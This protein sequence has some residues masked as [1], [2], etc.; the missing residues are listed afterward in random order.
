MANCVLW[1]TY[2]IL[3]GE[4]KIWGTNTVG[5]VFGAYYFVKFARFAPVKASTLPGSIRQHV[6]GILILAVSTATVAFLV[7]L[8][9]PSTFI[10]NGAILFCLLMFASPL[11]ALKTVL[12]S[13]SAKSIPLPF[14]LATILNCALWSVFGLLEIHDFNVYFPNLLGLSFGLV[15]LSLRLRYGD[16]SSTNPLTELDLLV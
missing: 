10:G 13:R 5:L 6:N 15:Q 11:A 2:G 8:Q 14:T 1:I 7:P 16:G 4:S 3:K 12:K 9:D